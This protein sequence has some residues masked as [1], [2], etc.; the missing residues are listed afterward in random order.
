MRAKGSPTVPV[1]PLNTDND[2]SWL[3]QPPD[4]ERLGECV[5][6]PVG[7]EVGDYVAVAGCEGESVDVRAIGVGSE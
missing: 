2:L 6:G 7:I 3:N 1:A 4:V 5:I